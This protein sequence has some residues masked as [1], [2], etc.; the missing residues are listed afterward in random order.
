MCCEAADCDRPIYARAHCSRHYRQLLRRGEIQLDR[1]PTECAATGCDRRAV[2]RGWCHGHYLRWSRTGDI[3]PH[4]PLAR[5][6]PKTC[7][8]RRL[9]PHLTGTRPLRLASQSRE[10]ATAPHKQTSW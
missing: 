3:K 1:A 7:T 2:T 9:R 6:L 4:V 10:T 5:L 8:H